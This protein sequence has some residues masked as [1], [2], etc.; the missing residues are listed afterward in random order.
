MNRILDATAY[1]AERH[2]KQQRKDVNASPYI[3]H[4]IRVAVLLS[5]TARITDE[6]TIIAA[7]LHDIVE[8]TPITLL[9]VREKFGS[10]IAS[11]VAE[12]TDDKSLPKAKRKELQI[13]HA[14]HLSLQAK[15]IKLADKIDNCRD[16]LS[17][18]PVGWTE[19]QNDAYFVWSKKVVDAG[20]R[21]IDSGL[22]KLFDETYAARFYGRELP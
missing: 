22:E 21:G 10:A 13:E 7:I 8:D 11:I 6:N 17:G 15:F 1:A 3:N 14:P 19:E 5:S 16:C 20:L 4:L 12:V 9:D 18:T 2:S